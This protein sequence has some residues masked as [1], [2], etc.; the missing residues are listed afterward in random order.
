MHSTSF[1]LSLEEIS[2]IEGAAALDLMVRDGKVVDLKLKITEF[3]RFYTQGI[4][5]KNVADVPQLLARICG[6]CSN[7]HLLCSVESVEKALGITP[8]PQTML[9]RRLTISGLIIRDHGLHLYVFSLPDVVGKDSLLDFDENDSREHE[10]LHDTFIVKEAG[11]QLSI[12]FGGRSVHAPYVAVGGYTKFPQEDELLITKEKLLKAR[13][14]ALRLI[15][16]FLN[17]PF[18]FEDET[19]FVGIKSAD[20]GFLTGDIAS[21]SGE[22]IPEANFREHLEHTV[23]PYSQASGYKFKGQPYMVGALARLNLSKDHL[24]P[25]TRKDADKALARFPSKNVYDNNLAQAIEILHCLDE[26]VELL[27]RNPKLVEEPLAQSGTSEGVGVGVIEA[28]RGTLFHELEIKDRKVVKADIVVP[29]GQN[30]V[31]MEKNVK[32]LVE[33]NIGLGK[34]KLALEIEKLIR[35]YDPC[36]SCATHFL[37][38]KWL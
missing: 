15:D 20:Y 12:A 34:E 28:P 21:T 38:V 31:S 17:C 10:L 25:K 22:T 37:K 35:A 7:A 24:H 2:K 30:Q 11:N 6:T 29:T 27:E 5:G 14:A 26:S 19:N 16:V 18:R 23:I 32:T 8:S 33:N 9:M 4:R 3:K 1:D 36:M 13:P